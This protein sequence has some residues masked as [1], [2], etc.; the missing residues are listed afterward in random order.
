[1]N[2]VYEY[3]YHTR[4][5]LSPLPP[6][7]HFFIHVYTHVLSRVDA[8]KCSEETS[9]MCECSS[10][11][12]NTVQFGVWPHVAGLVPQAFGLHCICMG[13]HDNRSHARSHH[14]K[15]HSNTNTETHFAHWHN[16]FGTSYLLPTCSTKPMGDMVHTEGVLNG[17][18]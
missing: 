17:C 7:T 1:M 8:S 4:M 10:P 14:I 5:P 9:L 16:I 12:A 3:S 2:Y 18:T 13:V 15:F 6:H 11:L